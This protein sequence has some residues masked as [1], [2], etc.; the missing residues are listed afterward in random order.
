MTTRYGTWH[1]GAVAALALAL[2]LA[3]C[4]GPPVPSAEMRS[5]GDSIARAKEDGAEQLSPQALQLAEDKMNRARAAVNKDN[6]A[7]RRLAEQAD[8]D[9]EYAATAANA[10]R[11]S[12]TA[13]ELTGAQQRLQQRLRSP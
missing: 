9:A 3:G 10:Q 7:A 8:V 13:S 4:A 2:A 11:V 12:N 5:A 1:P 6:D